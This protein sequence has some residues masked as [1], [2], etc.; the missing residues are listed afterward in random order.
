MKIMV[1]LHGTVTMHAGGL[2]RSREERVQQAGEG[3][4]SVSNYA[5]YVPIGRAA[6]KLQAW[7][8]QG[9][10]VVY[11]SS[12]KARAI[13]LSDRQ[14]LERHGFPDGELEFRQGLEKYGD[15]VARVRPDVLIEDD[16]ESIGGESE[17]VFPRLPPELQAQITSIVVPE[18]GGI[19]DLPDDPA[20]LQGA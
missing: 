19:D 17:M 2:G 5:A 1:F 12:Q 16:C 18:F 10:Q 7:R 8:Q 4:A 13:L 6:E 15:V 9:A 11:L 3:G 20:A 14:V